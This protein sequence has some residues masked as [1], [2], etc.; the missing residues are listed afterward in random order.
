MSPLISAF[1]A[2]TLALPGASAP[3]VADAIKLVD[4]NRVNVHTLETNWNGQRTIFVDY[5]IAGQGDQ[6][7]MEFMQLYAVQSEDAGL[8]SIKVAEVGPDGGDPEIAS[9]G[10]ANAD[11]DPAKELI[12][13]LEWPQSHYDYGGSFFEVWL[14]D[15]PKPGQSALVK[16]DKLSEHFGFGCECSFRDGRKDE[17]YRFK[18]IAAVRGEL[19]RLGY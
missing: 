2:A 16:L 19:K 14:Y 4:G 3:S 8:K 10:F 5:P 9:I 1:V 6:D 15:D 18:T 13:L 17:H 12:V 7:G 11:H